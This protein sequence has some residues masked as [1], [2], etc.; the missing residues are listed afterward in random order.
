MPRVIV[1]GTDDGV[2][3]VQD[4]SAQHLGLA[5]KRVTH[6]AARRGVTVATVPHDGLYQVDGDER[7]LWEGDA[8]SCA[9]A[10][11][12]ALYVGT[13]PAMIYRSDDGGDAWQRCSAI[14]DLPTR[15]A[16]TFPPLPH[17]PHVRS[18]D[19]LPRDGDSVLAGIEVGG[20]ILSR[21]RGETW[22]EMNEGVYVD[23]HAVRP[24]LARPTWLFACTGAGFYA[25]EDDGTTWDGRWEGAGRGYTVGLSINPARSGELLVTAG[26]GPPGRDGRVMHSLDG[27]NTWERIT[28]AGLPDAYPRVAVP[29]FAEGVAWLATG[30]GRIFRSQNPRGD[31]SQAFALGVRINALGAEGTSCSVT[32]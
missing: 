20:V 19:F 26:E 4:D 6:V 10:P 14:D 30:D 7:Q 1:V 32:I 28:D 23:V 13:E 25:S 24:D 3:A 12:G 15:S 29:L 2:R 9:V 5:G 8:R 27:G 16:W 21:D 17:E 18:I 11:D 31:W 22:R